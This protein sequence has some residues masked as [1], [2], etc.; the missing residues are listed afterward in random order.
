MELLLTLGGS[1]PGRCPSYLNF[2]H[3][4][5]IFQ[6]LHAPFESR[7]MVASAQID[8]L[9]MPC[10]MQEPS[11]VNNTVLFQ[12]Y[13]CLQLLVSQTEHGL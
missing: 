13:A 8:L 3:R 9:Q 6:F 10:A 11:V 1:Q 2:G 4:T 12:L 5:P 7:F